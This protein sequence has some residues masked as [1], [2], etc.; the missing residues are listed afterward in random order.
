MLE[1]ELKWSK[2]NVC[3]IITI[4]RIPPSETHWASKVVKQR[5]GSHV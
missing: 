3:F 1:K 2:D 5:N 4:S